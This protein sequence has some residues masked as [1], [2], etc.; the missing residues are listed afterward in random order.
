MNLEQ[1]KIKLES[2]KKL[3]DRL[4]KETYDANNEFVLLEEEMKRFIE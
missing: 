4:S 1:L 3:R 2:N